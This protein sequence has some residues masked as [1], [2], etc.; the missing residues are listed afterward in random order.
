[1]SLRAH[2]WSK[3]KALPEKVPGVL[4]NEK[5]IALLLVLWILA[6]LMF[7]VIEFAYTMRVE[8]DTV[9]N[10]KDE[11]SAR[12][13]ARAGI[14][15]GLAE[16]GV[17]YD[18][19][20]KNESGEVTLG[21]QEAHDIQSISVDREFNLGEGHVSYRIEDE[22]GRLNINTTT[23][24]QIKEL[25][26][27]TGVETTE[28]DVIAD[29]LLDWR[30]KNHVFHFNGAE[31]E[32]YGSLKEPYGAKDG[33]FDTTEELLLLKGVT[34]AIF[35]GEG[36][37][38]F[39]FGLDKKSGPSV[40]RPRYKGLAQYVT[41]AGKGKVNLNTARPTVLDAVLGK[42]KSMEIQLRRETEGL[43]DWPKYGG[44]IS[45][46][47]FSI[48]ATGEVRGMKVMVKAIA[49]RVPESNTPVVIYWNDEAKA[50]N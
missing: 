11:T 30:D 36:N 6:F 26:F 16:L 12:Y 33:P 38:P 3:K 47:D 10:L 27:I 8:T 28:R 42:G 50:T 40:S 15:M 1:M 43:I 39:E 48:H 41:V 31:D 2:R 21:R 20:F 24:E 4:K 35:Y 14:N 34:P 22:E 19:V 32:Y 9:R 45:S 23:R 44:G 5:G 29:S 46:Q 17:D 37:I 25:L 13:L 18:I 49:R 7:M